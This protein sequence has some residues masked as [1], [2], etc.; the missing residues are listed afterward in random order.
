[1]G[2]YTPGQDPDLMTLL[3]AYAQLMELIQQNGADKAEFGAS[4]NALVALM[5]D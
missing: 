1:M 3:L 5:G 2:G 4:R